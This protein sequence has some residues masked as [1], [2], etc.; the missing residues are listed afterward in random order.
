MSTLTTSKVWVFR[1]EGL[2]TGISKESLRQSF[3]PNVR[4]RI[5]VTSLS[6]GINLDQPTLTATV[7]FTA[8]PGDELLQSEDKDFYGF[9]PLYTPEGDI[10]ADIIAVTGLAGHAFGSWAASPHMWLRDFLPIDIPRARV[11]LYGY[12]SRLADSQSEHILADLSNNFLVKLYTMR[13]LSRSENRA[14]VLIGH[15][16]G[17]LIIK[18]A[19][20]EMGSRPIHHLCENSLNI[21]ESRCYKSCIY[22]DHTCPSTIAANGERCHILWRPQSRLKYYCHAN[23]HEWHAFGRTH[24]RTW[25]AVSDHAKTQ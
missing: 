1:R 3:P 16:L 15:G 5:Q 21:R 7:S 23:Y 19:L 6:P 25:L 10:E 2:P 8:P 22:A 9:T 24:P 12:D 4:D 17:C 20:I 14:I 11:L 13:S 18:D